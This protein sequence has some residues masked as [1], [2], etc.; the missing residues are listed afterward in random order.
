MY[1]TQVTQALKQIDPPDQGPRT[2]MI[3]AILP[4]S[5]LVPG[6]VSQKASSSQV[7]KST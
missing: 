3:L 7:L 2:L 4:G 6:V 5:S 1:R